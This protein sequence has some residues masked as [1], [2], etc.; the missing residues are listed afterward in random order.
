MRP[1]GHLDFYPNGGIIQ[2]GCASLLPGV[3]QSAC[4]HTRVTDLY[5]E[6]IKSSRLIFKSKLCTS[7]D[8]FKSGKVFKVS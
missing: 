3:K 7:Y 1:I 6:S 2:P 4:S 5:I 8:D